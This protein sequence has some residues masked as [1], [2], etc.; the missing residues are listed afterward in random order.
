MKQNFRVS[1]S[2][3]IYSL[4]VALVDCMK[5]ALVLYCWTESL[6]K[7]L[8]KKTKKG[9]RAQKSTQKSNEAQKG[10]QKNKFI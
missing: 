9:N 5:V 8:K 10:T 1:D 3:S 7:V 4:K 6:I 2:T